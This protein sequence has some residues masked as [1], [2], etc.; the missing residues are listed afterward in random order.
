MVIRMFLC[1]GYAEDTL[2]VKGTFKSCKGS[3]QSLKV[4]CR[5][6]HTHPFKKLKT[7]PV[8]NLFIV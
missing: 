6:P 3:R 1:Y 8:K 7:C 5:T 4:L 2:D